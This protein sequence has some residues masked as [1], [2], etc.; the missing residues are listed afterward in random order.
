MRQVLLCES[1]AAYLDHLLRLRVPAGQTHAPRVTLIVCCDRAAFIDEL[2]RDVAGGESG[3]DSGDGNGDGNDDDTR[4]GDALLSTTLKAIARSQ[5]IRLAFCPST[6]HLMAFLGTYRATA[7]YDSG[8]PPHDGR[9]GRERE[10]ERERDEMIAL[11]NPLTA[12]Q[13][14]DALSAHG[15]AKLLAVAVQVAHTERVRLEVCQTRSINGCDGGGTGSTGQTP[16]DLRVPVAGP[17][18]LTAA[19]P[20]PERV[21]PLRAIAARWFAF[22][23]LD[24]SHRLSG[25]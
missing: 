19:A 15:A 1:T 18:G 22:S 9:R 11:L 14:G 2:A 7:N 23:D 16:W 4:W 21:V 6:V 5:R 25:Y 24:G 17:G 13:R 20:E 10:R 8:C 3:G 12:L